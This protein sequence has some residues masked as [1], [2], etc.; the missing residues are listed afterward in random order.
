MSDT[1][2]PH[3]RGHCCTHL[4]DE[5]DEPERHPHGKDEHW[6]HVCGYCEDGTLVPMVW[7]TLL[8]E[9]SEPGIVETQRSAVSGGWLYRIVRKEYGHIVYVGGLAFA[10]A[11]RNS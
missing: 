11:W 9:P 1:P 4:Y 7:E 3:C 2:C 8:V 10:P 6:V 5:D